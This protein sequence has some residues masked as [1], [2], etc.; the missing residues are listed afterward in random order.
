MTDTIRK[1]DILVVGAGP[2]GI[3]AIA[4][5]GRYA[6]S[7]LW[8]DQ[9]DRP[10]GAIHRQP[11]QPGTSIAAPKSVKA[12]WARLEA[13]L[14]ASPVRLTPQT[15]FAGLD[16][17]GVAVLEDRAAGASLRVRARV[18]V[19]ALGAVERV[20]PRPGWTLPNVWTAGGMQVLL[21]ETGEAPKGRVLVAGNGPL[22]VALGAQLAAAGNAPVAV[23]EAGDPMKNLPGALP[24]LRNPR[25]LVEAR[26]YLGI[27]SSHNVPW[28]RGTRI[29]SIE[30]HQDALRVRT[31]SS[32]GEDI[33]DVDH[34]ALHDGIRSNAFGLVERGV[35]PLVVR[36]GD[37][38][39]ALGAV[40]AEADGLNAAR[41]AIMHLE[42]GGPREDRS[43]IDAERRAQQALKAIFRPAHVATL[44]TLPD[45]TVLCRCEGATVGMLKAM[46]ARNPGMSPREVK[47]NGRFGMGSC[48]GR[49]CADNVAM[50]LAQ[51]S[52][53]DVP[54][55][56][57]Q[58]TGTRWPIRP[59]SI[60]SLLRDGEATDTTTK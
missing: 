49:F 58:I 5:L 38:R 36:A 42:G 31:A 44:G 52:G 23:L 7:V 10:G 43:I 50:L 15:S 4:G 28:K 48:Q 16:S 18:I 53:D 33:F 46:L 8:I 21:K 59:V 2:A 51:A 37:C 19:L 14:A 13:A 20:M 17:D 24:L 12:Q 25:L 34:V 9:R 41:R 54:I 40:A 22:T 3:A 47:L 55:E 29:V 35:D 60:A 39:E 30:R 26:S 32:K 57:S 6:H 1:V 27:L 11:A 56:A 45:E